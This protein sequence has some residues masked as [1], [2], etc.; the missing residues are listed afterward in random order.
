MTHRPCVLDFE[1]VRNLPNVLVEANTCR[2]TGV[3]GN[4]WSWNNL[5][6]EKNSPK[7]ILRETVLWFHDTLY[8]KGIY[9]AASSSRKDNKARVTTG[10]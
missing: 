4:R 1:I 8:V 7:V 9:G 3:G 2:A 6:E 5:T 10:I